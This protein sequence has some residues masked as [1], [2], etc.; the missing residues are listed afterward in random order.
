MRRS[1]TATQG[2][3]SK[4]TQL[5]LGQGMGQDFVPERRREESQRPPKARLQKATATYA[6][7]PGSTHAKDSFQ[8]EADICK[9]VHLT[10][11]PL[12]LTVPDTNAPMQPQAPS[13]PDV[14]DLRPCQVLECQAHAAQTLIPSVTGPY[15]ARH[16][17]R[18][19]DPPCS[20]NQAVD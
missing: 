11:V 6:G 8:T 9:I 10:P 4:H 18:Y 15:P 16:R 14:L 13:A 19:R 2:T 17:R 20:V 5:E 3:P 12:N 7:K 1:P